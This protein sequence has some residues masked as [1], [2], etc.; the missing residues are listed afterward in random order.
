MSRSSELTQALFDAIESDAEP[1][2]VRYDGLQ[3]LNRSAHT[4]ATHSDALHVAVVPPLRDRLIEILDRVMA[5]SQKQRDSRLH[6]SRLVAWFDAVEIKPGVFGVGIDLK[7]LL[8]HYIPDLRERLAG[9]IFTPVT[10]ESLRFLI[11]PVG[12]RLMVV[13]EEARS[14][15]EP[16]DDLIQAGV[17]RREIRHGIGWVELTHDLL[18]LAIYDQTRE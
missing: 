9:I 18:A 16:L 7:A 14:K 12:F 17:L 11:S 6:R 5:G 4:S 8:L 3:I 2:A 15:L 10:M 1:V 13:E